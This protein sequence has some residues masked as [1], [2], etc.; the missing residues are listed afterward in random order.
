[1]GALQTKKTRNNKIRQSIQIIDE[2]ALNDVFNNRENRLFFLLIEEGD[3]SEDFSIENIILAWLKCT[4]DET[5]GI[6]T[7]KSKA[8][9]F[10]PLL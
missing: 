8:L 7:L 4:I 9:N 2:N 6:K 3:H 10:W 5:K 1:M